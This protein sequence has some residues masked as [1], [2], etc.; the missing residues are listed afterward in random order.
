MISRILTLTLISMSAG[1]NSVSDLNVK[2]KGKPAAAQLKIKKSAVPSYDIFKAKGGI[3]PRLD[4]G[5]ESVLEFKTVEL[6]IPEAPVLKNM[7]PIK[8]VQIKVLEINAKKI[9]T[10]LASPAKIVTS[11]KGVKQVPEL[12]P[13]KEIPEPVTQATEPKPVQ[14]IALKPQDYKLM[15]GLIFLEY[16]K[17]IDM[18]LAYF[19]ELINDKDYRHEALYHYAR[20]C[21][22][23]GLNTEVRASLLTIA[24]ESKSKEWKV[25]ATQAL[26][27][28]IALF[29][30]SDIKEIDPLVQQLEIDITKN[31][32]YN[33]YRAKYYLEQGQLG[34]VEDALAFIPETSK[35][36]NDGLLISAL[37]NYRQG[38]INATVTPLTQLL[39]KAGK[40]DN[41]RSV[42]AMTLARIQ[43]QQ[44]QYK[45]AF[46][47]YLEVNKSHSLWLQAMVEQAWAQI[48]NHDYE[49]AAGNMFSL[50]TEYFKNAYNPESYVVRTVGYLNLC[51]FGDGIQVL[52]NMGKRYAPMYGRLEKFSQT[53]KD[54][55]LYQTIRQLLKNPDLKEVD[56]LPRS[57]IIELARHPS[58]VNAQ[59]HINSY[60]DEIS[61]YNKITLNLIQREKDLLKQQAEASKLLSESRLKQHEPKVSPEQL[62]A[63]KE[64]EQVLEKRLIAIRFEYQ[65]VNRARS[66][67]KETREKSFVRLDKEKSLIRDGISVAL[68]SRYAELSKSLK[69]IIS[70]NEVLQ[71]EIY[72]GA[73]E[74][75]R[76]QAAGGEGT[77]KARPQLKPE[78]DKSTTW[79]FQ[80]E[81][82]EDEIGHFRSSLKNVCPPE[83]NKVSQ[84]DKLG[85]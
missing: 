35:Y 59:K 22:E 25:L 27:D 11:E 38:K 83:D 82:W 63:L 43:F 31:D 36:F 18:A 10:T 28:D 77:N 23:R 66:Q 54:P 16:R 41:V 6:K 72:S 45:E 29:D 53:H 56:G 57:F 37:F 12:K 47:T 39:A 75:L 51:Q 68:N 70:Q 30:V 14:L 74:Q 62:K 5:Q 24:K 55:N 61:N 17:S 69:N 60:E 67:V 50:H 1:A 85:K 71:Y 58:F 44:G 3:L 9:K 46:K 33:F 48:L 2:S 7:T 79:K 81:I 8:A 52:N 65:N 40:D 84:N 80:G 78:K 42:G 49:G 73:G 21:K 64:N 76:Y 4:I 32:A 26:A 15:E 34:Q 20:A 13:L 19:T